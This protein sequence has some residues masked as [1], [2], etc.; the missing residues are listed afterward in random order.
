[1]KIL[2]LS[3]RL[4]THF[5]LNFNTYTERVNSLIVVWYIVDSNEI[6]TA[7]TLYYSIVYTTVLL[8]TQVRLEMAK[9]SFGN[10]IC[11]QWNH[12]PGDMLYHVRV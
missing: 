3:T 2:N 10:R 11:E 12:L 1:L 6:L 9:F 8:K 5:Q 7:L 4:P